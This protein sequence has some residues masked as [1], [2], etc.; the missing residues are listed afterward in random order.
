M[1]CR[2]FIRIKIRNYLVK[3]QIQYVLLYVQEELADVWN[4]N[5]IEDL[6]SRNLSYI[7]IKKF[8]SDLKKEFRREDD[9]IMKVTELTK[10]E[11]R[12]RIIEE[13][14]QEFKRVAK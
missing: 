9:K 2:L 6:G 10:V 14:V 12:S 11:Q 13:F 8:L 3:E 4:E 1:A 7:I 5:I